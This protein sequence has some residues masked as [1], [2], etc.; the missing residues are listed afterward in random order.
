MGYRHA[1]QQHPAGVR[2][3]PLRE[4]GPN[5]RPKQPPGQVVS[6]YRE[7]T[8]GIFYYPSFPKLVVSITSRGDAFLRVERLGTNDMTWWRA[9]RNLR[10]KKWNKAPHRFVHL[11]ECRCFDEAGMT[12]MGIA[13]HVENGFAGYRRIPKRRSEIKPGKV[14]PTGHVL[15]VAKSG[16]PRN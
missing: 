13:M 12:R 6:E 15:W 2:V 4:P 9:N 10:I 8:G 7:A 1:T 11:E 5:G 3:S 14:L 16:G